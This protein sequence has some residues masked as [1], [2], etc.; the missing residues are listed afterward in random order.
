MEQP[1]IQVESAFRNRPA[2]SLAYILQRVIGGI[3]N[4]PNL[5]DLT[6]LGTRNLDAGHSIALQPCSR[7][8]RRGSR[9]A[10]PISRVAEAALVSRVEGAWQP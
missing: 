3:A 8:M 4:L 1:A 9:E 5:P 7:R 10:W 6:F 2:K